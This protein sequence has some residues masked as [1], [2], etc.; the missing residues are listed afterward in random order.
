M[1]TK[2]RQSGYCVTERLFNES[3]LSDM[4]CELS[5]I[6]TA[7]E[8]HMLNHTWCS[9]VS[10]AIQKK[11]ADQL[12][13]MAHLKPIQCT[14]FQKN[15]NTNWHVS[16]HQDRSLPISADENPQGISRIKAG[17]RYHQPSQED[18]DRV[19]AIRLSL[20]GC[21]LMNGGLKVLPGSHKEGILSENK[22]LALDKKITHEIPD[23][24]RGC[25]LIMRPLLLHASSKS[26]S[27]ALRRVLHF[28]YEN[29]LESV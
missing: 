20:D 29:R 12:P 6:K 16:W 1:Q 2:L 21:N 17:Q 14:Y 7:G 24:A 25:T 10:E 28:T 11:L 23:V 3:E 26:K 13:D 22:I 27:G 5:S 8:R 4:E 15:E 19:I 9:S 18:L